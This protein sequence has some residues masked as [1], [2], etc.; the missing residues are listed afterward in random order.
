MTFEVR[1][2]AGIVKTDM[3][4]DQFFAAIRAQR[5]KKEEA[6][7]G[8]MYLIAG[9]GNPG[10]EY[11]ESRHNFGFMV[12]DRLAERLGVHFEKE[13]QKALVVTAPYEGRKL[14]LAK[15]ITYMNESGRAVVPLMRYYKIPQE[16]LFVI[17]DD[18]DLPFGMLR[19]RPNGSNGGQKG[20]GSI[21]TQLGSQE[22]CRLR[23]GI[24]H[25][26][27]QMEV[28]DFVLNKFSKEDSELLPL[29]LDKAASCALDFVTQ[30][31]T[32]CMNHYNGPV[33][34]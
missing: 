1:C 3:D 5:E 13:Q 4:M 20:M 29:V 7:G 14:L 31:Y 34:K 28:V 18:M 8:E 24:G 2:Q 15:P 11:R 25:P 9:L 6:A 16:R 23:C 21:I 19:V 12:I 17:H 10:R 32:Y 33:E 27:G 26:P 22:F 30:G